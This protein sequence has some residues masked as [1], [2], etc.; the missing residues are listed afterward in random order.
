MRRYLKN[1]RLGIFDYNGTLLD[2]MWLAVENMLNTFKKFKAPISPDLSIRYREE[3]T[4]K[5]EDFYHDNGIPIIIT[6]EEINEERKKFLQNKIHL[7]T[8]RPDV[9]K[10]LTLCRSLGT[11]RLAIVSGEIEELLEKKLGQL[12]LRQHFEKIWAD[13][14]NKHDT[15]AAACE[16]FKVKPAKAFYVD[17][18]VEGIEAASDCGLIA[19]SLVTP[20]SY[21]PEKLLRKVAQ[22]RGAIVITDLF[23]LTQ[24]I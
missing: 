8:S 11:L 10:T 1:C 4:A 15:L 16:H 23:E 21:A 14:H 5:F 6:R 9:L 22:E 24:L 7:A 20:T 17:D 12:N 3:I 18:T 19:V 2:D 13:T